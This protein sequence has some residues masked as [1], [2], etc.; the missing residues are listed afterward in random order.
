[1]EQERYSQITPE[2]ARTSLAEIDQATRR[3]RHEIA[4]GI[5]APLLVMWGAI[6]AISFSSEQYFPN[7]SQMIWTVLI[8]IGSVVSVLGGFFFSP[9]KKGRF[10]PLWSRIGLAWLVLFAYAALWIRLLG[11]WELAHRG[12]GALLERKISAFISTICMF[13]YVLMGLWLDRFLLYVGAAVTILILV[14]YYYVPDHFY[15]WMAVTGGGSLI[16]SGLFI[17]RFWR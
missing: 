15:V 1:M 7:R 2:E 16:F 17:R 3:F 6:W 12:P 8:V 11:P 5:S 14:G 4:A 10:S 9:I 13:A